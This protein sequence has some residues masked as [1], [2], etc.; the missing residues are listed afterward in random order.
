[1]TDSYDDIIHL[2]HFVSPQHTPMSLLNRAAQ[3]APF[4]A[5]TGYDEAVK[6]T[7]RYTEDAVELDENRM[8]IINEQLMLLRA[9]QNDPP[10]VTISYYLS[11][12]RKTGGTYITVTGRVKKIDDFERIIVLNDETEIP[13]D[14]I[15]EITGN[16]FTQKDESSRI[17]VCQR[18]PDP[19][20]AFS[21]NKPRK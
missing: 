17:V 9:N 10:S 1:M 20:E 21:K 6:E 7:A 4:A 18:I 11:D 12:E 13:V 14:R 8:E 15:V 19:F 5:L 16:L 2:P 3:F